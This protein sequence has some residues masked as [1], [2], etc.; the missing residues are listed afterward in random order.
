MMRFGFVVSLGCVAALGCGAV[1][2]VID[3][4]GGGGDG[5]ESAGSSAGDPGDGDR[6]GNF[7]EP[8]MTV[9]GVLPDGVAPI[10][11][12]ASAHAV[13]GPRPPGSTEL[14]V[15]DHR[16][17]LR[18]SSYALG[19]DEVARTEASP[20]PECG[21]IGWMLGFDLP[22]PLVAGSYP[23]ATLFEGYGE[24]YE[25]YSLTP[26]VGCGFSMTYA[27]DNALATAGTLIIHA[28]TD[29]C[30]MGELR[31]VIPESSPSAVRSGGFVA[32]RSVVSCLPIG[33][34]ECE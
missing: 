18:V 3:H 9:C 29:D 13:Q 17:R 32:Q 8:A 33:T 20:D 24:A 5:D 28:V 7:P 21:A 23:L 4:G 15:A 16:V 25:G 27:S 26:E 12:L 34:I 10:D 31:D 22:E 1:V 6:L 19:P 30:V 2:D 11:G 14:P